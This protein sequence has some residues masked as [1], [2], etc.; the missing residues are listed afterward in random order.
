MSLTFQGIPADVGVQ[1]E[2]TTDAN[3]D[4]NAAF[5]FPSGAGYDIA[6]QGLAGGILM[7][8]AYYAQNGTIIGQEGQNYS[9]APPG[10]LAP[11]AKARVTGGATLKVYLVGADAS[12]TLKV[13][14][15]ARRIGKGSNGN[16]G[17]CRCGQ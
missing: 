10:D 4:G 16:G 13:N 9:F 5:Q 1:V 12:T 7:P 2:V 17:G 6:Y 3:G 8:A 14:I 15:G 11:T